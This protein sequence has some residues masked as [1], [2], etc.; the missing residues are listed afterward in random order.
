MFP[1]AASVLLALSAVCIVTFICGRTFAEYA[2]KVERI[3]CCKSI[4]P[5][6][7]TSSDAS[8]VVFIF[9]VLTRTL[10]REYILKFVSCYPRQWHI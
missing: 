1:L 7:V 4:F 5:E 3:E 6:N 2:D 10:A 8:L 9:K